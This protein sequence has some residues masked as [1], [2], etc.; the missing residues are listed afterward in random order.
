MLQ[1]IFLFLSVSIYAFNIQ[2]VDETEEAIRKAKIEHERKVKEEAKKLKILKDKYGDY[3]F[4]LAKDGKLVYKPIVKII[5][6]TINIIKAVDKVKEKQLLEQKKRAEKRKEEIKKQ[7]TPE[8]RLP[9]EQKI[10][11]EKI[12]AD[13]EVTSFFNSLNSKKIKPVDIE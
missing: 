11:K 2:T 8:N 4:Y 10:K 3:K 7:F 5:K 9:K 6:P 12:V 1:Y 13:K